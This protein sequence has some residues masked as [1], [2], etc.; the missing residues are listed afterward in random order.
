MERLSHLPASYPTPTHPPSF[1]WPA[2]VL[3]THTTIELPNLQFLNGSPDK[4]ISN[5]NPA[6]L[7]IG[8]YFS[9]LSSD[10]DVPYFFLKPHHPPPVLSLGGLFCFSQHWLWDG[11]YFPRNPCRPTSIGNLP[12]SS[13]GF[14][15]CPP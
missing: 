4:K 1:S 10:S 8:L 7:L 9:G 11:S 5:F 13:A 12:V 6:L 14:T 15:N 3:Y 2:T